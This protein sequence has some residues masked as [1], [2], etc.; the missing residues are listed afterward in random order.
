MS[1]TSATF[2]GFLVIGGLIALIGL[3]IVAI[4]RP[5]A[6]S[7]PSSPVVEFLPPQQGNI[8]EHGLAL[9][10]DRRVLSAAL[11]DLAVRNRV[12]VLTTG[13]RA[14]R[15]RGP[16]AIE[17]RREASLTTDER[18]FLDAFRPGTM[19]PR[20]Q[21]RYLRA[22]AD[23]GV[24]AERPEDAPEVIFLRGRGSFRHY[25]RR[26]LRQFFD[27]TRARMATD[28][29]T[30]RRENSVH[31]VLLSLLFLATAAVGLIMLIGGIVAGDWLSIVAVLI[32]IALVLWVLTLAPP[33]LLRFT[34][35]GRQLRR[36]LSGL[37]R[38]IRLSE[39]DR[40]RML[41]SPDGALRTPAGALTPGGA[42]L[43]LR[44]QPVVGDPVA[45][46]QLDRFVLIERLLPYAILF[47]Q[48]R[49]WQREFEHLG[50]PIEVSQ[51]LR[52]LGGTLDGVVAVLEVLSIIGQ[53]IRV[54]GGVFSFFGRL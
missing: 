2:I 31:L 23:I 21:R 41:Q 44:P 4:A 16:L 30:H 14:G 8:F 25:R 20:Q 53:V 9:R 51:N 28:G 32:D 24:S 29:F 11:I 45:Q 33:P 22:L 6:R 26:R 47:R 10:A 49:A 7:L 36:H 35:S 50:G 17:V 37:R 43:G 19:K 15:R 52:V 13:G 12:R 46:S 48:E 3:L 38:Y 42:A 27:A 18:F 39:Q 1:D 54:I 5:I 34:E 40:L